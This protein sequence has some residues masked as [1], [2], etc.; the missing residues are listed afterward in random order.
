MGV[1]VA[2]FY[3]DLLFKCLFVRINKHSQ[4]HVSV[5]VVCYTTSTYSEKHPSIHILVLCD[6]CHNVVMIVRVVSSALYY[7]FILLLD[8]YLK[9][10]PKTL[11]HA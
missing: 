9:P 5:G 4:C 3:I 1:S 7:T 8:L 2:N 11:E 6:L 10:K